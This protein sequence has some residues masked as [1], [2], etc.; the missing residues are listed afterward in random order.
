MKMPIIVEWM[1]CLCASDIAIGTIVKAACDV[2]RHAT[3]VPT[4]SIA[5][6]MSATRSPMRR[7]ERST[8][9]STAPTVRAMPNR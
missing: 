8:S 4:S 6:G 7:T 2:P 9:Q 5:H 1:R 3:S